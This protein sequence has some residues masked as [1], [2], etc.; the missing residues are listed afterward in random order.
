MRVVLFSPRR[1]LLLL[2]TVFSPRNALLLPC[3]A[4][5]PRNALLLLCAVFS[6]RDFLA[7]DP[8]GLDAS[9]LRDVTLA[10][11]YIDQVTG[12]IIYY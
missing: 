6:P 3:A 5:S 11:A 9:A 10:L 1:T 8:D 4:F 12:T 7:A 2:C